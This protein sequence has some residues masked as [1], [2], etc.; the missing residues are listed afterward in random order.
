MG[1]LKKHKKIDPSYMNAGSRR[2]PVERT[3]TY[4]MGSG[5]S[6]WVD[7]SG[8]L[9]AVNHRLYRQGKLYQSVKI[10]PTYGIA[11]GNAVTI[12][13]LPNTW[14]MKKAWELARQ[15]RE[16]QLAH[17]DR[18]RGRWDDFRLGW[19][20]TYTAQTR[21][22]ASD[23]STLITVDEWDI[24]KVHDTGDNTDF[25][26]VA[27][28]SARDT[29]NNLFGV[30][31]QY[32][33]IGNVNT[34]QPQDNPLVDAYAHTKADPD[35]VE[36]AGDLIAGQGNNAPYD[37]SGFDGADDDGAVIVPSLFS[38]TGGSQR[39]VTSTDVPLGLL[40]LTN[41]NSGAPVSVNITVAAGAY[42]GVKAIDW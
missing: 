1:R 22:V 41:T 8:G 27:F 21:P 34:D 39:L 23:G 4:S 13:K 16:E 40:L 19:N 36:S 3:L 29:S 14:A 2:Y 5:A 30:L 32:D 35:L 25:G 11:E 28:G 42:K 38:Q 26:F 17:S 31:E 20:S 33:Q 7:I 12:K 6:I 10:E 9:S 18:P 24:S 37:A 15:A